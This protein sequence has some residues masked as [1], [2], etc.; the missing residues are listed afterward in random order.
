MRAAG[1]L[2]IVLTRVELERPQFAATVEEFLTT[3]TDCGAAVE[4]VDVPLAHYG[5]ETIDHTDRT[6]DA[7]AR[8]ARSVLGH[9]QPADLTYPSCSTVTHSER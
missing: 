3:A 6:R 7:V 8:A 1:R 5:F 2:P 9:L 4:V